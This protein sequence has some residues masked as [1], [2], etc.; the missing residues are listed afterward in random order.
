[1]AKRR[2]G[3][4]LVLGLIVLGMIISAFSDDKSPKPT[5]VET[6]NWPQVDETSIKSPIETALAEA[7]VASANPADPVAGNTATPSEGE[8]VPQGDELASVESS[9]NVSPAVGLLSST[10]QKVVYSTAKLRMRQGPGPGFP[11]ITTVERGTRLE[12]FGTDGQWLRVAAS[13]NSGWVHRD[14]VSDGPP[15][16]EKPAVKQEIA[17]A[18]PSVKRTQ[19]GRSGQPVRDAYVGTCDCPYDLMRN[20]RQCG[21]KSAYSRP[22]GRSPQ[23]Y[24]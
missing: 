11:T 3:G 1:M 20:G 24:F 2:R 5:A 8:K 18:R 19:G 12:V 7:T 21:G 22:G 23:C 14:F 9:P 10:P 15:S 6:V 17:P 4:K 16:I 13:L